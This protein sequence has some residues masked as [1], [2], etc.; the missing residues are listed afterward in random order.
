MSEERTENFDELFNEP[1]EKLDLDSIQPF[2]LAWKTFEVKVNNFVHIFNRPD[3]ETVI[4]WDESKTSE[5]I[6]GRDGKPKTSTE[7]IQNKFL[8]A[9]ALFHQK[10]I[11]ETKNYKSQPSVFLQ[12]RAVF[13]LYNHFIFLKEGQDIF[14]DEVTFIELIGDEDNPL[15]WIEHT[16]TKPSDNLVRK[17]NSAMTKRELE[18]EKRGR[19]KLVEKPWIR[20]AMSF[21]SQ[22]LKRIGN[23]TVDEIQFNEQNR[24]LFIDH[25]DPYFQKEI[26]GYYIGR[27]TGALSD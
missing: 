25:I 14:D 2:N 19:Q 3:P 23:A 24:Q 13:E 15:A 16:L 27:L 7:E 4:E 17:I 8:E 12:S 22:H 20:K 10:I 26:V 6:F 11:S 5:T 18:P 21:Y 9:D 1:T